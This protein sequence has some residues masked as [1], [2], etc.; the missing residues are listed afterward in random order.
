MRPENR[1]GNSVHPAHLI[2]SHSHLAHGRL[3][4]SHV[5]LVGVAVVVRRQQ[6]LALWGTLGP[7]GRRRPR[8]A[9]RHR[10]VAVRGL[11]QPLLLH[12]RYDAR[13]V[14]HQ[15]GTFGERHASRVVVLSVHHRCVLG[16]SHAVLH[17]DAG[18][19][20]RRLQRV[21]HLHVLGAEVL[22]VRFVLRVRRQ[23]HRGRVL[24]HVDDHVG[25]L[26]V[27]HVVVSV[28]GDGLE[29]GLVAALLLL[30]RLHL[31]A[32][33]VP[34]VV[35]P[36]EDQHVEDQ[37]RAPDGDGDAEGGAVGGVPRRLQTGERVGGGVLV[38]VGL[39]VE[40]SRGDDVHARRHDGVHRG[41][42]VQAGEAGVGA[43][44][45]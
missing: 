19:G 11:H 15:G 37:Q 38:G 17:H 9:H 10:G 13:R 33:L 45:E 14:V 16:E 29:S 20:G 22:L 4:D 5:P 30:Q 3:R 1:P 41:R 26:G 28:L 42:G 2:L 32:R 40:V 23:D 18:T 31:H 8:H 25:A 21:G 12:L 24:L 6:G 39:V 36:G 43:A 27:A 35:H 44:A 7:G 34:L